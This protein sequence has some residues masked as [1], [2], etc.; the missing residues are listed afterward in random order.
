MVQQEQLA[1]AVEVPV[2]DFVVLA[3][4]LNSNMS[5]LGDGSK[6]IYFAD[7]RSM[8]EMPDWKQSVVLERRFRLI[9][10]APVSPYLARMDCGW[11]MH[12]MDFVARAATT[13]AQMKAW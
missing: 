5:K 4:C 13:W 7:T 10:V 8:N 2:L 1:H 3:R 6:M 9:S 11:V 12:S